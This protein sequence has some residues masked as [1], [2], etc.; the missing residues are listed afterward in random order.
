MTSSGGVP[1]FGSKISLISN[2]EIRYEG[3]LS[4]IDTKDSTDVALSKVRS[5]G[6]EDRPTDR[7]VAPR[8][9]IYEYIIFRG[10]DIKDTRV[11]QPPKPH[12]TL[13]GGLPNDPAIIQHSASTTSNA[14]VGSIVSLNVGGT[15]FQTS[16]STMLKY[17]NS[18][19]ARMYNE[20]QKIKNLNFFLDEDA[21]YFRIILNFLR[22][23]KIVKFEEENLFDGVRDLAKN[24]ELTELVKELEKRDIFSKVVLEIGSN[25]G[26]HCHDCNDYRDYHVITIARKFLTRVPESHL[27]KFFFGE[28]GSQNP[29]SDWIFKKGPNRYFIGRRSDL[30]DHVLRFMEMRANL[31][32]NTYGIVNSS[33]QMAFSSTDFEKEL[34][35]YGINEFYHYDKSPFGRYLI[36]WTENYDVN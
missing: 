2:S 24:L 20:G 4:T 34:E 1:Y 26:A 13:K 3:I 8:D 33:Q 29:L 5:F 25:I 27:A 10:T 11:C 22:K 6:T 31:E 23:E 16:P 19:L 18:K 14:A 9:E 21:E 30:T 35:F 12:P 7:P 28:Q 15:I 36:S 32:F 17:P